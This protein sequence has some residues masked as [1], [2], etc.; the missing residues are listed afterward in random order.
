MAASFCATGGAAVGAEVVRLMD[1]GVL[2]VASSGPRP[3]KHGVRPRPMD[4]NG[5]V[6]L[7]FRG[8]ILL[9]LLQSFSS[10]CASLGLW[11][12]ASSSGWIWCHLPGHRYLATVVASEL[13]EQGIPQGLLCNFFLF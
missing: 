8:E 1:L 3:W 4:L 10:D 6:F 13:G 7:V 5:D 2:A 12:L 9:W 11:M